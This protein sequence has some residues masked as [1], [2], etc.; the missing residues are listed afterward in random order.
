MHRR[1]GAKMHLQRA[2]DACVTGM[3]ASSPSDADIIR[4]LKWQNRQAELAARR[5][6]RAKYLW[7][8]DD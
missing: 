5:A 6:W 1:G 8:R 2:V 3:Y 4:E 7:G